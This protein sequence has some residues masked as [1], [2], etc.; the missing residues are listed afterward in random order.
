MKQSEQKHVKILCRCYSDVLEKPI[1]ATIWATIDDEEK[2][3]YK[4]DSIPFYGPGNS[5]RRSEPL[6][7]VQHI[8]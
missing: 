6:L 1:V 8:Y 3:W 7:S 2:G 4:I 5:L